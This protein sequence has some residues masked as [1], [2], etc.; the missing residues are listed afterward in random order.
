MKAERRSEMEIKLIGY[1]C[2]K[3]VE[4]EKRLLKAIIL[5]EIDAKM[6]HMNE[7]AAISAYGVE[8]MPAL[9]INDR[10]VLSGHLPSLEEVIQLLMDH[11]GATKGE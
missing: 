4:L 10:L 2:H 7:A 5:T 8:A 6:V 3:A 1:G 9:V 11:H